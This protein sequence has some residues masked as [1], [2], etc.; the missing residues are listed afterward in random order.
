MCGG[1]KDSQKTK[2]AKD[3]QIAAEMKRLE[4]I[5]QGWTYSWPLTTGVEKFRFGGH[6]RIENIDLKWNGKIERHVKIEASEF[7][8]RDTVSGSGKLRPFPIPPHRCIHGIITKQNELRIVTQPADKEVSKVHD[9]MP[10][11]IE[12]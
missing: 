4:K 7:L 11:L 8:E 5:K 6:A 9:R 1:L 10:R 2:R 12:T 3:A